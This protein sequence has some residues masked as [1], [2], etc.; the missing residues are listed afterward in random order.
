MFQW[1]YELGRPRRIRHDHMR[2]ANGRSNRN[3][4]QNT[5]GWEASFRRHPGR[6]SRYRGERAMWRSMNEG[7]SE[8]VCGTTA[9]A[10]S[11]ADSL[12]PQVSV[13]HRRHFRLWLSSAILLVYLQKRALTND[14]SLSSYLLALCG[15]HR[16]VCLLPGVSGLIF[17][18]TL[19][20]ILLQCLL[21]KVT[22][23]AA[24]VRSWR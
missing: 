9:N 18:V 24:H 10:V 7:V 14:S 13:L 16:R 15:W 8:C 21:Y 23:L 22:S 17:N 5:K 20:W 2:R 19:F 1:L 4:A 3:V 11:T 6:K 12:S